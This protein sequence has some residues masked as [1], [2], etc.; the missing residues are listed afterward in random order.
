MLGFLKRRRAAFSADSPPPCTPDGMRIY[1]IGDI[2]GRCDLLRLLQ[3][4]IRADAER[5]PGKRWVVIYLGDYV[6]R[7]S[8]SREV[9]E[10]LC[11]RPLVGFDSFHLLGNHEQ[12]LLGFMRNPESFSNWLTYGGLATLG[13]YGVG[14]TSSG[15]PGALKRMARELSMAMPE[16]HLLFLE[17]LEIHRRFGDYLFVHAG[18]R[19]DVPIE[20]QSLDDLLWIRED[21]LRYTKLYPLFVVHGHHIQDEPDIRTN[22]IGIDTGAFATGCLTSLVLDGEERSFIDTLQEWPEVSGDFRESPYPTENSGI[23]QN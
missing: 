9:L 23:G 8:E 14:A 1:A 12:A 13:S 18:I 15:A 16:T 2:H 22:R 10:Q 6:D 17:R 11:M 20:A 4:R 7:G 5:H 19:P 21:F 3:D